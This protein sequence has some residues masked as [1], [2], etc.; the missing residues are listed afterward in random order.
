[1]TK[2]TDIRD[3]ILKWVERDGKHIVM[4]ILIRNRIGASTSDQ[5]IRGSY[6]LVPRGA[7]R[8]IIENELIKAGFSIG[9]KAS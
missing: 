7:V 2:Q 1:M 6:P 5:L 8:T 9:G 4:S 3:L